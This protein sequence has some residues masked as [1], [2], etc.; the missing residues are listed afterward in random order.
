[1]RKNLTLAISNVKKSKTDLKK[2]T[3][4]FEK[5]LKSVAD[6]IIICES[7]QLNRFSKFIMISTKKQV[8]DVLLQ[9]IMYLA[10]FHQTP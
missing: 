9:H 6:P 1:M 3:D 2:I 4:E 10:N 7:I 8:L 5:N